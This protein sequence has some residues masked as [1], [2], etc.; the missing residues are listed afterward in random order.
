M[1]LTAHTTDAGYYAPTLVPGGVALKNRNTRSSVLEVYGRAAVGGGLVALAI[2]VAFGLAIWLDAVFPPRQLD[3]SGQFLMGIFGATL[4]IGGLTFIARGA[5]EVW[6]V[7]RVR[8]RR[9]AYPDQPWRWDHEWSERGARDDTMARAGHFITSGL[10]LLGFMVPFNLVGFVAFR[11]SSLAPAAVPFAIGAV[12]FDLIG[13]GTLAA[14]GYMVVRRLKFG[15]AVAL[16]EQFPFRRGAT[17]AL[18]VLAP[19]ALPQHALVTTTLRCVQERVTTTRRGNETSKQAGCFEVYRDTGTAEL[20]DVGL[21]RRALRVTF[22]IPADVAPTDLA[23]RPCRYWEVD[24][25]AATDGV[26][27]GAR[28]LVPVY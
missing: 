25:E 11:G 3:G 19:R 17:L 9:A 7:A 23:S 13:L 27:Y 4:V 26:D 16:F 8:R 20:L 22:E 15:R 18:R 5:R 24:V 14:G 2:G 10:I 21:G 1:T 12:I 28:F 6:R